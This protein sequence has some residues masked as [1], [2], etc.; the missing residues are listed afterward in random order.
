[1]LP[2]DLLHVICLFCQGQRPQNFCPWALASVCTYAP[3]SLKV[4][5]IIYSPINFLGLILIGTFRLCRIAHG[6]RDFQV[7]NHQHEMSQT[8]Y[9]QGAS[10]SVVK[11]NELK[12]N[13][14]QQHYYEWNQ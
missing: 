12:Q 8:E 4:R 7:E 10:C 1:M 2:F 9:L 14:Q 5:F 6:R 13:P 3:L 11:S